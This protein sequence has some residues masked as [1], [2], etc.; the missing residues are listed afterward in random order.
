MQYMLYLVLTL[1]HGMEKSISK[2]NFSH[3]KPPGVSERIWS[4]NLVGSIWGEYQTF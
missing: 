3:R 4:L 2:I 1:D